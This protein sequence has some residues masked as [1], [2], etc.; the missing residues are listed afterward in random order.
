MNTHA[1]HFQLMLATGGWAVAPTES[2]VRK[3][4]ARFLEDHNQLTIEEQPEDACFS[5][6]INI[7]GSNP[8]RDAEIYRDLIV[9]ALVGFLAPEY[10]SMVEVEILE[11]W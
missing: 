7:Y 10:E 5:A 11:E 4:L 1:Y 9:E 6:K 3:A 8:Y 2:A